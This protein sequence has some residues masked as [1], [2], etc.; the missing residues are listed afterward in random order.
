MQK[1]YKEKTG[2]R[3]IYT[4]AFLSTVV[5][6]FYRIFFSLPLHDTFINV[7]IAVL[8]VVLEFFEAFVYSIYY[9]NVLLF[10]KDSPKTP[11]IKK[12]KF[13][14]IDILIATINEDVELLQET[15]KHI[16]AM[17]YP[18]TILYMGGGM[19]A[20]LKSLPEMISKSMVSYSHPFLHTFSSTVCAFVIHG[21]SII[22]LKN[23]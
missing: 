7:F 14:E 6:I 20:N 22:I 19:A 16:K 18:D 17:K 9:F 2:K 8:I 15:I 5:Y 4:I 1:D 3:I 23:R 11:K 21:T 10:K 12:E 13:P